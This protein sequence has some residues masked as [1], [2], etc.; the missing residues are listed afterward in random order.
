M[1]YPHSHPNYDFILHPGWSGEC[2][3][4]SRQ[5]LDNDPVF[6]EHWLHEKTQGVHAVRLE[7]LKRVEWHLVKEPGVVDER[8]ERDGHEYEDEDRDFDEEN[9]EDD[10]SESGDEGLRNEGGIDGDGGGNPR[11]NCGGE[12]DEDETRMRLCT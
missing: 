9:E 1:V 3:A 8:N 4:C 5:L 6:R 12:E 10:H 11:A 7:N 2:A